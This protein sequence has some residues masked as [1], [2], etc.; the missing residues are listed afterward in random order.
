M[1]E[2]ERLSEIAEIAHN[3]LSHDVD[4]PKSPRVLINGIQLS[5]REIPVG[6][7]LGDG[8]RLLIPCPMNMGF[9]LPECE[10]TY[11]N[12]RTWTI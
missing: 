2:D 9:V 10:R 8:R 12:G 6:F 11:V 4:L 5:I 3:Q 1:T 7:N